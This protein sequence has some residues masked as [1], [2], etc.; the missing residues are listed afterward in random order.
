MKTLFKK[1]LIFSIFP[2]I[3]ILCIMGYNIFLDP[4]GVF[5]GDISKQVN[6]PNQHYIKVKY[7]INNPNR[8]NAFI[9]GNS[10]VGKID[11]SKIKD[12]NKWYNMNYSEGLP[13][14]HLDNLELFIK[15]N[16]N[17]TKVVVGLDEVSAFTKREG[18]DNESIRKPFR[19]KFDLLVSYL[20]LKPSYN[21]FEEIVNMKKRQFYEEG[22]YATIY[23]TGSFFP[24]KKDAYIDNNK[25]VH[26][27][28]PKFKKPYW[29]SVRTDNRKKCLD[30]IKKIKEICEKN[31]IEVRFFINPIFKTT[32]EKAVSKGFLEFLEELSLITDFYDFNKHTE[33]TSNPINHYETS[34]YRPLVGD[35]IVEEFFN[36]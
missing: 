16:V 35:F 25:E 23:K 30:D 20:F 26:R 14:E 28:A 5:R 27:N 7:I 22:M 12:S 17:I 19:N 8:Y 32:Y 29:P 33:I 15:K 1:I 3:F 36:K 11:V 2:I 24:N 4:Y 34:H 6:E 21:L 10:R 31:N 18:H 9:F 13:A